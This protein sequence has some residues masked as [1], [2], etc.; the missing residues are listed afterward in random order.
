MLG[1]A[2]VVK[3]RV[4]AT[5]GVLGDVGFTCTLYAHGCLNKTLSLAY[6]LICHRERLMQQ[7]S[8]D[9]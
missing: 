6:F 3:L 5:V 9:N 4:V 1:G 8:M 2:I 7:K